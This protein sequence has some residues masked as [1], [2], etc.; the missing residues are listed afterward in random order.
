MWHRL[1][2]PHLARQI[3]AGAGLL[4]ETP[5]LRGLLGG[6]LAPWVIT[7]IL[8]PH[9]Q[10]LVALRLALIVGAV[11]LYLALTGELARLRRDVRRMRALLRSTAP[12]QGALPRPKRLLMTALCMAP[13]EPRRPYKRVEPLGHQDQQR[14]R[15]LSLG[16]R[17]CGSDVEAQRCRAPSPSVSPRFHVPVSWTAT[18]RG[19]GEDAPRVAARTRPPRKVSG[20]RPRAPASHVWSAGAAPR[21]AYGSPPPC[22]TSGCSP[23][24]S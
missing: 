17:A 7:L 24:R 1:V 18:V 19:S 11:L 21:S 23:R 20:T 6:A 4:R 5:G 2:P 3:S 9:G 10:A 15:M 14:K 22:R 8:H 12:G 16:V 13:R